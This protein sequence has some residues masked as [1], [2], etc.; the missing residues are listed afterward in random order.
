M[1]GSAHA[2]GFQLLDLDGASHSLSEILAR[3][4]ALLA[5]FKVSC[6]ICQYTFPFLERIYQAAGRER[7][8][9][10][11]IAVSQDSAPVTRGFIDEFG[12]SFPT[13]LDD[14]A[15][16]Y[17]VSNAYG[18]RTVPTLFLIEPDGIISM[19]GAGFSK[20]ELEALGQRM[21]V[22]PFREGERVPELRPG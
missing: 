14:A 5:F 21:G 6:P 13:L 10:Q 17:P 7:G 19:S 3:G 18:L 20:Q 22:A 2:P 9:V 1:A 12:V 15:A 11:I 8:A 16:G 4:P